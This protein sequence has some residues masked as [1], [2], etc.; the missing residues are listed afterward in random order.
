MKV[1]DKKEANS[2]VYKKIR[3]FKIAN[4]TGGCSYCTPHGGENQTYKKRGAKK[5]KSKN[6]RS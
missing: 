6:K 2:S 3:R 1:N 5:P 4:T